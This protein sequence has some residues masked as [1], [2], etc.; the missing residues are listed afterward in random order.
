MY[1]TIVPYLGFIVKWH[2]T[3]HHIHN[4]AKVVKSSHKWM[5]YM[6]YIFYTVVVFYMCCHL[7]HT[8]P[9]FFLLIALGFDNEWKVKGVALAINNTYNFLLLHYTQ[10]YFKKRNKRFF[11]HDLSNS[12][13]L[14]VYTYKCG[15]EKI[16]I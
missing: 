4:Q 14:Y 12:I 5:V 10:S 6:W 8:K 1:T 9:P 11:F 7:Q 15:T 16:N 2:V 3:I 13:L